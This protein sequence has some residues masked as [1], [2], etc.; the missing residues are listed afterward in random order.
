MAPIDNITEEETGH[1]EGQDILG[2]IRDQIFSLP[3][4]PQRQV[5]ELFHALDESL[6]GSVYAM[7]EKGNFIEFYLSDVIAEV[8]ASVTHGR[9][10]YGH[11]SKRKKQPE[12]KSDDPASEVFKRSSDIQFLEQAINVLHLLASYQNDPFDPK[13]RKDLTKRVLDDAKFVRLVYEE[14]IQ[15]FLAKTKGYEELV[16]TAAKLHNKIHSTKKKSDLFETVD[17][18]T[19]LHDQMNAIEE[20]VKIDR[21]YLYHLV[22]F[23]E[24]SY[25]RQIKIR[26]LIYE[27]YLRIVYK[28][29]KKHATNEQQVLDNFQNGSQGLL[30]AISCYN[31]DRNVSFSSYAHWWIRQAILFHIKDSSNFVKL[32]VTTWQTYTSVEKAK[33]R[34]SARDGNDSMEALSEETGH[35]LAK[36]KEIY[37]SVRS[38]HVH[39]LDY[40]MDESGK[41]MLIDVIPDQAQEDREAQDDA[42]S[43]VAE[44]LGAL[45]GEQRWVMKLHFGLI[46]MIEQ[47]GEFDPQDI[48]QEKI[49]QKIA[50]LP[51]R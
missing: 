18:Y 10:I 13:A 36:L 11:N 30:R 34:L 26:D 17:Q 14:S 45:T 2:I 19:R 21:A 4:L 50:R 20:S 31:L 32:P 33:D 47:D 8:A 6:Q 29:S 39:S 23:I 40:V 25:R 28:E 7:V 24:R 48:M 42:K 35:S 46:G 15:S 51:P 49:R 5:V 22:G 44:R 37:D 38:S 1:P 43:E 12:K 27:P 41:L 9:T 16:A 3:L